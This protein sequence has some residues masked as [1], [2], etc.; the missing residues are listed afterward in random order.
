MHAALALGTRMFYSF[1]HPM[2]GEGIEMHHPFAININVAHEILACIYHPFSW[3]V[4]G[5]SDSC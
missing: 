2:V 5:I 4:H 3:F 1:C